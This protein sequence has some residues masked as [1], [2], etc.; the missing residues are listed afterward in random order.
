[1]R[2]SGAAFKDSGSLCYHHLVQPAAATK[3]NALWQAQIDH[4]IH[5][6]FLSISKQLSTCGPRINAPLQAEEPV[7]IFVRVS[8]TATPCLVKM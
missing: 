6:I 8:V 7:V 4:C 2:L 3:T 5:A 1:M